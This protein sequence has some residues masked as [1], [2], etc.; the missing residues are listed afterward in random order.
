MSGIRFTPAGDD[1]VSPRAFCLPSFGWVTLAS[2]RRTVR[3]LV[4]K[5]RFQIA[6]VTVSFRRGRCQVSVWS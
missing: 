6:G 2:S 3:R 1:G 4:T 5:D